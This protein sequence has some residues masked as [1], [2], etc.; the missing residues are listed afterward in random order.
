MMMDIAPMRTQIAY[1]AAFS[2]FALGDG[3]LAQTA[4]SDEI[5]VLG[6]RTK[7]RTA[8]DTPVPV[9]TFSAEALANAGVVGNEL[10]QALA[11]SAPSFN[12][13]RQSN[14]GTSDSVRAGQLRGLSPDQLLVLVNGRRIHTSS[15]VNSETKIG[16]GVAAVDFNTLPLGGV[17]RVEVLRDGAGAQYGSDAI[18]GVINVVLDDR[19]SG[20]E[21]TG[22]YGTQ[23]TRV[24]PINQTLSDGEQYVFEAEGGVPIFERGFIRFGGEYI[25]RNATNRAGFDQIPFF[26][27]QTPA[28]LA[29]QGQRNYF[30]GDPE[31]ETYNLWLNSEVP[32]GAATIYTFGTFGQRQTEGGLFFRY[33]DAFDNVRAVYPNGYLPRTTGDNLDFN[34]SSGVKFP[35]AG[36]A[37]DLGITYGKNR[38]EYGVVN[39]LNPSLGAQSPTQFRSAAYENGQ[40]SVNFDVSRDLGALALLG[41]VSIAGGAEYR[42]EGFQSSAG[43]PASF[44]AGPFD[45]AI[46][47]QGAPGLT[48]EDARDISR[49]VF[50]FYGEISADP[51]PKLQLSASGRYEWYSDFGSTGSGKGSIR[52]EIVP[53]LAIRGALGN[54]IRAPNLAQIGFAD[55]STNFGDNRALISTRTV[56]VSD[57]IARAL[58]AQDLRQERAFSASAGFVLS[59]PSNFTATLDAFRVR[60]NDR[61][62]LSERLFGSAIENAV[63]TL[64]G[65]AGTQSV[66]FFTNAVDTRTFGVD[67]VLTYKAQVFGG[68]LGLSGAFNY[69]RTDV[70]D[71]ASSNAQLRAIDPSL[72]LI[73]VEELNTLQTATPRTK[74]ILSSTYAKGQWDG[75]IRLS[76]FGSAERVFNFGGGFEPSQRYGA[77]WALDVEAA[78]RFGEHLRLSIGG[79]NLADNY[80]DPSSADINFFGNLPFD[81]L[82]PIGVNGRYV[83]VKAKLTY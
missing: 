48:P 10:G 74:L 18:A 33:P 67:A 79:Q 66:R 16:R 24:D 38:F 54:T 34:I 7:E 6:S 53:Q 58:G 60:V 76:R 2:F 22:S 72:A 43:E 39:S 23:I 19:P 55:R 52:Y 1:I 46:G 13:P 32:V 9:D 11:I 27:D 77:E 29:L 28:N 20:F 75:L 49:D 78:R 25:N 59:L 44:Q 40:L 26:V 21:L 36:F 15:V 80:P 62:T 61:V 31:T 56:P 8:L 70:T 57:P 30:E 63:A 71:F 41:E 37:A 47:A 4:N 64:P 83:Y 14:S 68:D 3:A 35:V 42:R 45:L 5:V 69:S 51:T 17:K 50:G 82:S 12:F 65:G 73:G 81:I